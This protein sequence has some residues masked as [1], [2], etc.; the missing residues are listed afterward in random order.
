MQGCL[1]EE[2]FLDLMSGRLS[3]DAVSRI[4]RHADGCSACFE[5]ITAA[6]GAPTL[7]SGALTLDSGALTLDAGGGGG[8][9]A[10]PPGAPQTF[11][12]YQLVDLLGHGGMGLVYDAVHLASDRRVALKT[13]RPQ[14][15][16]ALASIR[17]EIQA[18]NR[19][20]HPGV[21]RVF[22]HGVDAQRPWYAMDLIEGQTLERRFAVLHRRWPGGARAPMSMQQ[23]AEPLSILRRLCD[24]LSYVHG[25][26]VVHRDLKPQNV[27]IQPDGSPIL[28][29]F[30]LALRDGH[31]GRAR[32]ASASLVGGTLPYMPPEQIRGELLDPR[33]D[34]YALGCVLYEA[35]TGQPPFDGAT[36]HELMHKQLVEEPVPPSTLM[37]ELD[38]ALERLI[39]RL[40]RKSPR[41]RVGFAEDVAAALAP[42]SGPVAHVALPR[43]R[44]YVYP[45]EFTGRA[46]LLEAFSERLRRTA[47]GLGGCVFLAGESGVGK[48]RLVAEIAQLART[49]GFRVVLGEGMT[50]GARPTRDA[51]RSTAL[52]PL[53]PLLQALCE[54]CETSLAA[55]ERLVG[56]NGRVLAAY[57]PALLE[58]PGQDAYPDPPPLGA[59]AARERLL[60][61]L[62]ETIAR[63]AEDGP[64]LLVI[65]DLQWADE[66]SLDV[67]ETAPPELF[68][69]RRIL[70]LGAYRS[71]ETT[72]RL[73][74]LGAARGA[75]QLTLDGFDTRA[76]ARMVAG[77]LALDQAPE[78][79]LDRLLPAAGGNPF[80]VAEYLRAA[81]DAGWIRRDVGSSFRLDEAAP[82][83]GSLR[84]L[85]DLRLAA[86]SVPARGMAE[87][88]SVLGREI[89]GDLL[90]AIAARAQ[91]ESDQALRELVDRALLE[92][93]PGD[94]FRFAHAKLR[95]AVHDSLSPEHGRE[96]HQRAAIAIERLRTP[97]SLVSFH[98]VLAHHWTR[99]EV[100][101]SAVAH[102]ELAGEHALA[103]AAHAEAAGLF[104]RALDLEGILQDRGEPRDRE[105]VARWE[106]RLGEAWYAL[107]DLRRSE[108]HASRAL[109]GLGHPLPRSRAG[110]VREL[111]VQVG[112]QVQHLA[113]PD[114][115]VER[116]PE[117]RARLEESALAAARVA[118]RRYFAED[119]LGLVTASLLA[120]NLA[121]R[122]T[123]D[124]IVSLPYAQLGYLAGVAKLRALA[125]AYFARARRSAEAAGDFRDLADALTHEALLDACDGRFAHAEDLGRRALDRLAGT[126]HAHETESVRIILSHVALSAGRYEV[127][128][129][130]G[131]A[132]LTSARARE[133]RQHEAFGL[134][135]IARA[136][137]RLGRLDDAIAHLAE[138]RAALSA[139]PD[140]PLSASICA[141]L[142]ALALGERGDLD[143][144]ERRADAAMAA[145]GRAR[146]APIS[147][148]DGYDGAAEVYL[149]LWRRTQRAGGPVTRSIVDRAAQAGAAMRT[150][151]L[152]FPIGRPRYLLHLG[153]VLA[154]RGHPRG[155]AR[156]LG[157]A[158]RAASALGMPHEAALAERLLGDA[159]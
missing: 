123:G 126:H 56:P 114:R 18:L 147:L 24:T 117:Q 43:A 35:V 113:L 91:D 116:S 97:A 39:L 81:V 66:L 94:R 107:G 72:P 22:D 87:V 60:G 48:T 143:E 129:G 32:A 4:Q 109:A 10:L 13:V 28:V 153:R 7:D 71:E 57:E 95:E 46:P 58:L 53:R 82:L 34:L 64:L 83:P 118:Y 85:L 159:A 149:A 33:A 84:E 100:Y 5:L 45:P 105:R 51:E 8:L 70:L 93:L 65:D 101:P 54:A 3:I 108:E 29:D 11:A 112:R 140:D 17:R 2:T 47:D 138:A 92:E 132:L 62:H 124:G 154:L 157:Q 50:I 20:R 59:Q 36:L 67:L 115:D 12:G 25:Q 152:V 137:I 150:F 6:A 27:V 134:Y 144:A 16:G 15:H 111:V 99:A 55:T 110:W 104:Q 1:D 42:F 121:E 119:G 139:M 141:G 106:R 136:E 133:N 75:E 98:S 61:A 122:A 151:A 40:L 63:L 135:A 130:H 68:T 44:P 103:R 131:S 102:L 73:D 142:E 155:A 146:P 69:Q 30:G 19:L 37:P 125:A 21:V 156:V 14:A 52:H 41:D 96:L 120:V 26:G 127:A 148:A 80:F 145:I 78:P 38:P 9:L 23:L 90:A 49:F 128:L 89:D 74:R 88:A 31:S 86:L 76:I 79:L 158:R 77:M